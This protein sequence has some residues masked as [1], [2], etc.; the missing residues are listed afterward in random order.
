[1]GRC[2]RTKAD[3][4]GI[5]VAFLMR[6]KS[7]RGFRTGDLTKAEVTR[8]KLQGRRIDRVIVRKSGYFYLSA[9]DG[10][11]RSISW[12]NFSLLQRND[13]YECSRRPRTAQDRKGQDPEGG[14]P[15]A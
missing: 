9:K 5:P 6:E 11:V 1:M 3:R 7:V 8:G 4:Q 15:I 10:K 12:K 2:Q 14:P 13:S